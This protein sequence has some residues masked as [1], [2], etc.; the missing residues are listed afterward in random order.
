MQ[1]PKTQKAAWLY[2]LFVFLGSER[3]KAAG[4]MLVET[5]PGIATVENEHSKNQKNGHLC[6]FKQGSN[7]ITWAAELILLNKVR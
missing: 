1:I 5:T 4:K 3:V 2:C 7:R 6:L